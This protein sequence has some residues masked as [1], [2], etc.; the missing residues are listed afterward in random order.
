MYKLV[1]LSAQ[2]IHKLYNPFQIAL[3]IFLLHRHCLHHLIDFLIPG[4]ARFLGESENTTRREV[5]GVALGELARWDFAIRLLLP[6][7][8]LFLAHGIVDVRVDV[9]FVK[10]DG[11]GKRNDFFFFPNRPNRSLFAR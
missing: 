9:R 1:Q 2:V 11:S 7:R 8:G 4:C 5:L 6:C 10:L 3:E